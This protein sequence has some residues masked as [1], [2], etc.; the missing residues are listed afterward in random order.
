MSFSHSKSFSLTYVCS[1]HGVAPASK[2]CLLPA[3]LSGT[4]CLQQSQPA[5][6]WQAKPGI[7]NCLPE[8]AAEA[9]LMHAETQEVQR[10]IGPHA[11][12]SC[13][14]CMQPRLA[15]Q[16]QGVVD[17]LRETTLQATPGHAE[18]RVPLRVHL[19]TMNSQPDVQAAKAGR[20]KRG[21]L[22]SLQ[23]NAVA[24]TPM[25]G[26]QS[27]AVPFTPAAAATVMRAP[28]LGEMFYSQT[29]AHKLQMFQL[30]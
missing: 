9:A 3:T 16:K 28:R 23:E 22:E 26:E 7:P 30:R 17:S 11:F 4:L 18:T 25:P 21:V 8:S 20:R 24:A 5:V 29:G 14:S 19:P 10:C 12:G 2:G 27:R 13:R 1:K 6:G 15:A